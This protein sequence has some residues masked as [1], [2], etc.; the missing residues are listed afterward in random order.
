LIQISGFQVKVSG[1]NI[2]ASGSWRLTIGNRFP[3]FSQKQEA[4]RQKQYELTSEY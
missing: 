2:Q 3:A 1:I 4:R